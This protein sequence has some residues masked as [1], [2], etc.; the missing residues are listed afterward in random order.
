MKIRMLM[1]SVKALCGLMA[2]GFII[3]AMATSWKGLQPIGT[4]LS[5]SEGF[6]Q[7]R[8]TTSTEV[9]DLLLDA[10]SAAGLSGVRIEF[11]ENSVPRIVAKNNEALYFA[12]GFLTAYYR[13]WQMDFL[14][15][16]AVGRVAEIVGEQALPIDRFMRRMQMPKAARA[17]A[18][19]MALDSVTK[20]PLENYA[21]GVNARI[22]H[23]QLAPERYLPIEYRLFGVKP[24]EWRPERAASLL[25]FMTWELTG[26]LYDLKLNQTRNKISTELFDLLFP[27]VVSVPQPI[28][29]SARS[30]AVAAPGVP[31]PLWQEASSRV[32]HDTS[33][34]LLAETAD[35]I[36]PDPS[37]GS[38]SWVLGPNSTESHSPILAND[39]HLGYSLPA[40]WF[41]I[42]LSGPTINVFG[43]SLPG[44]PG[45]VVGFNQKMGWAVTNGA[46]DVLDWYQLRFRDEH[47]QEY[48]FDDAWRPVVTHEETIL[49][50]G[51]E[52]ELIKIRETHI[53]PIVFDSGDR[54][55]IVDIPAGLVPQWTGSLASNELRTFLLLNSATKADDCFA[56][57][58]AYVAPSQNFTCADGSG[59]VSY[60]H[61]G[62]FPNRDGRDGR[63]VAEASANDDLWHGFLPRSESPQAKGTRDSIVTANQAPIAGPGISQ[64]GWFYASPYRAMEIKRRLAEKK[65]WRAE[66]IV[67]MQGGDESLHGEWFRDV[68]VRVFQKVAPS[69][70]L[71]D[72]LDSASMV[73]L[74]NWD[75]RYRPE[76]KEAAVLT[77][78]WKALEQAL[79]IDMI[80]PS[81]SVLW[82]QQWRLHELVESD[83]DPAVWDRRETPQV[84]K[85]EDRLRSAAVQACVELKSSTGQRHPVWADYQRTNIRHTSRI[86]GLGRENRK[87]GG[88]AESIFANKGNHGPT[89][90]MVVGFEKEPKAWFMIPGG[91]SGDPSSP[92]YDMWLETWAQGEMKPYL[93]KTGD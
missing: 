33:T 69:E 24:E 40:L 6:W 67:T 34:A 46:D 19:L 84:E 36:W 76:S 44:A 72:C 83:A 3:Y 58:E 25:K 28:L 71:A 18:E 59:H 47:R 39:L 38:N 31:K 41:P 32:L 65:L 14:S 68:V 16:I 82:P 90:K 42:Q 43:A 92:D 10:A 70:P 60:L 80:G 75:G 1:Q 62:L 89:W 4:L 22:A 53:G 93:L 57:L 64:F 26:Y 48:L 49:V 77:A 23:T 66:E 21:K 50:A 15:R 87:A 12:Q 9:Q 45:V 37:N 88:V 27:R 91:I 63:V 61:A 29:D 56:A 5:P 20:G 35:I 11:D 52:P 51:G 2:T 54:P 85:L 13:L 8:S 78:W 74:K 17:S 79:W 7:H 30:Q 55:G 81:E 86:P 73:E